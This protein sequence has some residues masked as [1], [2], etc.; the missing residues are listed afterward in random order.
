MP[1]GMHNTVELCPPVPSWSNWEFS[2]SSWSTPF[3]LLCLC[4]LDI[5]IILVYKV[6]SMLIPI[7]R[8]FLLASTGTKASHILHWALSFHFAMTATYIAGTHSMQPFYHFCKIGGAP[9]FQFI[10]APFPWRRLVFMPVVSFFSAANDHIFYTAVS[11]IEIGLLGAEAL[12]FHS[13][14]K[15]EFG[16]RLLVLF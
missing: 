11:K 3:Y 2:S 16:R 14:S 10:S 6:V 5:C 8:F 7:H 1:L 13:F 15:F 4:R 12:T 9:N